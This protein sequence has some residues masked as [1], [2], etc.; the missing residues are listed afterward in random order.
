MGDKDAGEAE[1]R[2][3]TADV[4]GEAA[5]QWAP[6]SRGSPVLRHTPPSCH[7]ALQG[8]GGV[9]GAGGGKA[10]GWTPG[11]WQKMPL[12]QLVGLLAVG[13]DAADGG[14][15]ENG[16]DVIGNHLGNA[17]VRRAADGTGGHHIPQGHPMGQKEAPPPL[18]RFRNQPLPRRRIPCHQVRAFCAEDAGQ[19]LPEP[20]PGMAVEKALLPGADGGKA[21]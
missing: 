5:A 4:L 12:V 16:A 6:I 11:T 15:G 10:D 3:H 8:T 14:G 13:V 7:Q 20:V 1:F 18:H 17:A 21:A 9:G 2:L 19:H